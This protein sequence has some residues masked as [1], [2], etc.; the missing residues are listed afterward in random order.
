MHD[1]NSDYHAKL[2]SIGTGFHRFYPQLNNSRVH[3]RLGIFGN[4]SVVDA[5]VIPRCGDQNPGD[6]LIFS[7]QGFFGDR[8]VTQSDTEGA[9]DKN[10]NSLW[11]NLPSHNLIPRKSEKVYALAN[12][13]ESQDSVTPD[14][15]T[16]SCLRGSFTPRSSS[17]PSPGPLQWH[18]RRHRRLAICRSQTLAPE[19]RSDASS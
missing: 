3:R 11:F 5:C 7:K 6:L 18:P 19:P 12:Y 8:R 15:T 16:P 2:H 9:K 17:Q 4:D 13:R 14:D 10:N 1:L